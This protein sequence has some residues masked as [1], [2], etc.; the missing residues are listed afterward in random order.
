MSDPSAIQDDTLSVGRS[1]ILTAH[2][3]L[4]ALSD[5]LSLVTATL[6]IERGASRQ[7]SMLC[8]IHLPEE[9]LQVTREIPY[10][11]GMAGAVQRSGEVARTCNLK[12]T[13][14]PAQRAEARHVNARSA[15]AHPIFNRNDQVIGVL[16]M[17][18]RD[19]DE[20]G[21]IGQRKVRERLR[22][23]SILFSDHQEE[24]CRALDTPITIRK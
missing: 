6:H 16:G 1:A 5:E 10:G 12:R 9:T 23:L 22:E 8:A 4:E 17:A 15:A 13:P 21:L 2:R 3:V 20:G 11:R 14:H 24:I 7:L 19:D 18:F